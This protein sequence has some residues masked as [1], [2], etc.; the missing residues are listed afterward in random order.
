MKIGYDKGSNVI[1]LEPRKMEEVYPAIN[2]VEAYWT[3]L[4]G[5]AP[6]PR[7]S[8]IDPRGI[9]SALHNAFV[10]ERLAPTVARFRLAGMHLADLMGMEVRGMPMTALFLPDARVAA[11]AAL[12]R[13][14]AGPSIVTLI[15]TGERGI[16]RGPLDARMLLLPL[17]DEKGKVTRVLGALQAKGQIGRQPRRF[18]IAETRY[19]DIAGAKG[20]PAVAEREPQPG[21]AEPP[22]AVFRTSPTRTR[23]ALRL[24]KNDD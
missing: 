2:Q 1:S 13:A 11:G 20:L 15:L 9:E 17:L 7:R 22:Q 3:A 10:L 12:D 23:P 5:D 21:F 14:F 6:L 19:V 8:K 16:G 4:K 18:A 24:V